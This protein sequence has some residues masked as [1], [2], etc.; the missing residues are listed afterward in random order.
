[1]DNKG[2][3][4]GLEG[5][6]STL[7]SVP[8]FRLV[9][10]AKTILQPATAPMVFRSERRVATAATPAAVVTRSPNALATVRLSQLNSRRGRAK[11]VHVL[12]KF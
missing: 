11:L 9:T 1:M 2:N 12:P 7:P 6:P 5:L 8:A 10:Q 4:R 3:S